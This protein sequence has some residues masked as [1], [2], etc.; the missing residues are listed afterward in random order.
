MRTKFGTPVPEVTKHN[1]RNVVMVDKY[2][3]AHSQIDDIDKYIKHGTIRELATYIEKSGKLEV[4][5]VTQDIKDKLKNEP[6]SPLEED[7]LDEYRRT[8][9]ERHESSVYVFTEEE[10]QNILSELEQSVYRRVEKSSLK[11]ERHVMGTWVNKEE[12]QR[13]KTV[14]ELREK[15][16]LE[17]VK[18]NWHRKNPNDFSHTAEDKEDDDE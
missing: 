6:L 1:L 13:P 18:P 16:G 8:G 11:F 4:R 10:L 12:E 17:P 9:T 3:R 15:L 5:N 7:M 2:M 14:N